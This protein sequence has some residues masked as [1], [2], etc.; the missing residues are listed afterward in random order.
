MV[1]ELTGDERSEDFELPGYRGATNNQMELQACIKALGEAAKQTLSS[2]ITRVVVF[3]DSMYV[4]DNVSRAIFQWSKRQWCNRHGKPVD[5]AA[6]WKALIKSVKAVYQKLGLR[7]DFRWVKG[8]SSNQHNRA[9]DK[10]ARASSA[11]PYNEPVTQVS[12]RRKITD[13]RV[14][15]GSVGMCG[16]RLAIRVIT[17]EYLRVQK[18]WK[19]R[20]EVISRASPFHGK[21]DFIY[22]NAFLASGHTYS[23]RVNSDNQ[24]PEIVK[25]FREV[26]SKSKVPG[27]QGLIR[28]DK[29]I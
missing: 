6:L 12:V 21:V 3:T 22:S 18:I 25:V 10:L 20:Y 8:H 7:V 29:G 14:E 23:V 9:V 17:S 19:Y 4:V 5:N 26:E 2:H 1:I 13:K 28:L 16:Q 15:N 11:Q 24:N 27:P